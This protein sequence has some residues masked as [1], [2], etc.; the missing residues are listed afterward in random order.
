MIICEQPI[1]VDSY[2]FLYD[3]L[4]CDCIIKKNSDANNSMVE[5]IA[6]SE[7][8]ADN[9]ALNV[10][11]QKNNLKGNYWILQGIDE[12]EVNCIDEC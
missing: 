5:V 2:E 12:S 3:H 4:N 8:R 11:F 7:S 9:E 1:T 6:Y 10:Y